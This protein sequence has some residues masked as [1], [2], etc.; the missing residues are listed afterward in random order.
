MILLEVSMYDYHMH[1][2]FSSDTNVAMKD[3]IE[4]AIRKG[5]K[6]ITFTDHIDYEYNS[7]EIAFE[8]DLE[9]YRKTIQG[10][11]SL[12]QDQIQINL[13]LEVGIQP[14]ILDKCRNLVKTVSPDFVIASLHNVEKKDLYL[15]EYYVGKTPEEALRY[16][17]KEL[18]E[19]LDQFDDFSVIGHI[20]IV[21]RY[22]EH[23]LELPKEVF[24]DAVTPVLEK[25]IA[26]GRGIEVNTS[27]LRQGLNET[28]PSVEIL[29]KYRALGG[30]IITIGSDA[31]N[32]EDIGHS[33]KAVLETLLEIGFNH[34]Y[35]YSQMK[36]E[37][38]AIIDILKSL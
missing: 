35:V 1:S 32:P 37:P 20:D 6:Q 30:E 28:L 2:Y 13:G 31:H 5:F 17:F 14:H 9:E 27:G 11:Q 26:M 16:S 24:V 23:V 18:L 25:L 4:S 7:P 3:M 21:K 10:F 33:F 19:M 12:Y 22:S 29:R 36:P 8:F 38:I 34:I 15:G